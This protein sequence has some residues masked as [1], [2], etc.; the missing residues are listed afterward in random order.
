M[1]TC[2]LFRFS[3]ETVFMEQIK[4]YT[5]IK[6]SLWLTVL[7]V[8]AV[9]ASVSFF[10]VDYRHTTSVFRTAL[11]TAGVLFFGTCLVNIIRR[12][13]INR[14]FLI[15]D[16]RGICVDTLNA[17][18]SRVEWKHIEGFTE[19]TISSQKFIIIRVNNP[20]DYI[21]HETSTWRRNTMK[22]NLKYNG[23]PFHIATHA[24][25]LSH[26]QLWELLRESLRE[27]KT[28]IKNR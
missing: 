15:I 26:S 12:L 28:T 4:V 8:L 16:R 23:S 3:G 17:P 10:F 1:E 18:N 9:A 14:L 20:M 13:V 6:K 27:Y 21:E 5:S 11:G 19:E 2:S 22:L 24:A 7:G 25:Q